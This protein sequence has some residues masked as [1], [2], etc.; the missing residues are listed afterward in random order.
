M[1]LIVFDWQPGQRLVLSANRDEFFHRP[2][3]PLSVWEEYPQ[4]IAG[5]D[6][7]QGGTWLGVSRDYRVAALTNVRAPGVAPAQ[8]RSRGH[9]VTGFLTG[10]QS[11]S[12]QAAGLREQAG[13][14]APFN[15]L[16]GD[17]NELWFVSNH[18]HW[19][20]RLLTP[21]LY[22][23]SNASLNTP[24]PKT[25]LAMQQLQNW[26]QQPDD[27][28]SLAGLLNRREPFADHELPATGIPPEWERLLSAQFIQAPGYGTRCS[29]GLWLD[30]DG[31]GITEVSWNAV[32][33]LSAEHH[34]HF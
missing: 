9:L 1:C 4:L 14:F 22:G 11:P 33:E 21:G 15:L 26:L 24:W 6:L 8:P 25:Q 23:L 5:R 12:V 20:C 30:S 29:T 19:Q 16:L 32:G 2:S 34:L 28:R 7:V 27:L 13:E 3:A 10:S 31:A 17:R 18:P